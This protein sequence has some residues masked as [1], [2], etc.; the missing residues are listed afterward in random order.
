MYGAIDVT[1]RPNPTTHANTVAVSISSLNVHLPDTGSQDVQDLEPARGVRIG[2]YQERG[3]FVTLALQPLKD[4][5]PSKNDA[6]MIVDLNLGSQLN[7]ER[8]DTTRVQL[9]GKLHLVMGDPMTMNGIIELQGGKLDVSGKQFEVES[10][11][12][13][14]AGDPGNPTIVATASWDSGD[15]DKHRVYATFSGTAKKGKLDLRA[16]PPLTQDEVLSLLL[17]GSSDGSLGGGSTGANSAATAVGAVGGAATQGLNRALS[18]I[19]NLDVSTRVDTSTG[20]A[21][22]ELVLQLSPRVAAQI[23]RA[24]G[25]PPPGAPPDLTFLTFDFRVLS[26]WSLAALIGDRG[27]SGLDLV[28][29]KRY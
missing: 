8:G 26:H 24:L 1:M 18:N 23:T 19:S 7:V 15:A 28:W 2:T 3:G 20:S 11:S 22:P 16:E 17:T 27:Q 29:R 10:G 6:P 13:T 4:S 25:E 21:R 14:F 9:G 5:D 12:V